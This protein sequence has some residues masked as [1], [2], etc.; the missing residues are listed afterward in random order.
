MMLA[1][2]SHQ[3]KKKTT[4]YVLNN[5]NVSTMCSIPRG[6]PIKNAFLAHINIKGFS[7]LSRVYRVKMAQNAENGP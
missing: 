2:I 1:Q 7:S 5:E 4:K 6:Q 3:M